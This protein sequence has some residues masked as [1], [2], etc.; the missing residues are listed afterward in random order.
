M[1]RVAKMPNPPVP[2]ILV[3][4]T[5]PLITLAVAESLD[6]LLIPNMPV[7]IPDAVLFE[8]TRKSEAIGAIS[9]SEWVQRHADKVNTVPTALF[10]GYVAGLEFGLDKMPNLGEQS[11][12]EVIEK[13]PFAGENEIA[14]LLSEDDKVIRGLSIPESQRDRIVV[15]TTHDFLEGL[16]RSLR[17]NS[18]DAVYQ[19]AE[20]GGRAASKKQTEKE[21]RDRALAAVAAAVKT[22]GPKS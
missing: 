6:Y 20:D 9:I 17:I 13:T 16:E 8:A 22:N 12:F 4:D 5:G 3:M 21:Q 10:E 11:A 14:I 2:R 19:R 18:V 7:I 1:L 15:I